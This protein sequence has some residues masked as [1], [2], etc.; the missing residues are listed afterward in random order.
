M[1]SQ[2]LEHTKKLPA[3]V[4]A[5]LEQ[6]KKSFLICSPCFGQASAIFL[7]GSQCLER[8]SAKAFMPSNTLEQASAS[9]LTRSNVFE[10]A[11]ANDFMRSNTF[12]RAP[13]LII[14]ELIKR[15]N[16]AKKDNSTAYTIHINN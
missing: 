3:A 9:F 6:G 7:T 12:E 10:R 4:P 14:N 13:G 11:S 1:H 16:R 15:Q 8:S 5:R 2:C